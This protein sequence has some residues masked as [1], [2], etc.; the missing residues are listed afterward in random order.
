MTDKKNNYSCPAEAA[1]NAPPPPAKRSDPGVPAEFLEFQPDSMELEMAPLP[2]RAR[3][4]L[5][6]A[7]A[8]IVVAL[9]WACLAEIDRIVTG[10]GKI[11]APQSN[12]VLSAL[13][14]AVIRK[15]HVVAGQ[16]VEAGDLLVTLDSTFAQA[17]LSDAAKR[18]DSLAAQVWR[19]DCELGQGSCTPPPG[20]APAEAAMQVGILLGRKSEFASKIS[21]YDKT[22]TGLDTQVASLVAQREQAKKR[23]A[24]AREVEAMHVAVFEKGAGSR[25]EMLKA[26]N[27]RISYEADFERMGNE[28]KTRNEDLAKNKADRAAFAANWTGTL[29]KDLVDSRRELAKIDEQLE[30]ARRMHELIELRSP[31]KAVVLDVAHKSTGSV[32]E[33]AENL[34]TLVPLDAPLEAQVEIPAKE[35]G[36][37]REGDPARIKLEAFPFQKHG[38]VEGV[39][40]SVSED[41]FSKDS[42]QGSPQINYR[43]R[44]EIVKTELREVPKDFRLIPGMTLTAE[45]KVGK[46]RIISYLL[47][48]VIRALDE[49]MREP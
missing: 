2:G 45:V 42:P 21:S 16:K 6:M 17:D 13:E 12:L 1:K 23:I 30:K 31:R 14:P 22:I 44:I 26:Q 35:I 48:P 33:K 10:Q 32:A 19:I 41:A 34:V 37:V 11:A 5:Y 25:L 3:I 36:F 4:S 43:A 47:Y 9:L 38:V 24:N 15:V 29:A 18:Q 46:R 40:T 28:I 49:S 8:C 20:L 27:D 39:V 7:V